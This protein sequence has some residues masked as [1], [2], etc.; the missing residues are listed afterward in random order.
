LTNSKIIN[1]SQRF[2][3]FVEFT[4]DCQLK[5]IK[6]SHPIPNGC[7]IISIHVRVEKNARNSQQA[8]EEKSHHGNSTRRMN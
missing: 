7:K 2:E 6:N 1:F 8:R 3:I 5:I 4:N